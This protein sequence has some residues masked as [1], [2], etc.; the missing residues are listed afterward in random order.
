[1]KP[2][3]YASVLE[4]AQAYRTGETTASTTVAALLD[5]I[6][7][8]DRTLGAFQSVYADDARA[9]AK[10]A[11]QA[12]RTGHRIGPFHGIPFAV[13]D[14]MDVEGRV[15]TGGSM[16]RADRPA[17]KSATVARR[18][19]AAGGIL[20][21]KTKTI[22]FSMGGWGTNQHFG[23]PRN[24]WDLDRHR[25]PG[26]SSSGSAVAVASGMVPDRARHG[27]RRVGTYAVGLVRRGRSQDHPLRPARG[28]DHSLP[29]IRSTRS[30]RSSVPSRTPPSS[31]I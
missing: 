12:M 19:L 3:V 7:T 31:S 28:R 14:V 21:G 6:E 18:L 30:D 1:M 10:A 29:P 23:T 22:E 5:R 26:G 8:H 4:V 15:T 27:H 25:V 20:L 17:D 16:T 11:D 13:K 9:A 24:P 2:D